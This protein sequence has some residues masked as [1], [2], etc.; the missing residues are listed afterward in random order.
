MARRFLVSFGLLV[1]GLLAA[2]RADSFQLTTGKTISGEV[3]VTSA[4]DTGVQIKIGDGDYE[5]VPWASFAQ[6]DLK[7]FAQNRKLE[8]FVEPFIEITAEEKIKKTEVH[9]KPPPRLERPPAQS[10]VGAMFSSGL[11]VLIVLLLY[12]ANLY[13]GYEVSIFR[14]QPWYLVCGVAAVLPLVGPLIFL[15]MPTRIQAA[16]PAWDVPPETAETTPTSPAAAGE[17]V[18]PMLDSAVA[19]PA[20]LRLSHAEPPP[21]APD[22]P[23][24]TRFQRGQYTFNRRFIET[25][26]PGF[27]G[28]VRREA[29]RDMVLVIKAARGEY[30]AHRISRISA[31]DFHVQ[32]QKGSATEEIMIPF[33][34]VQELILKHRD[35][36]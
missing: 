36:K 34:E 27:F 18:N 19:H 28:V 10:L 30:V 16:Q 12:A 5:R 20:G 17:A 9:I 11:G 1:C 8:P 29:D 31:G 15:A 32:V 22:L 33:V 4:S 13:A 2:A 24:S 3:L 26:F 6:E 23:A 7:K 14:A 21:A 35:A 25:K